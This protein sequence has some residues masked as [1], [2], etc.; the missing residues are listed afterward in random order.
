MSL[1]V[2]GSF[3]ISHNYAP[4]H[5]A[6]ELDISVEEYLKMENGEQLVTTEQAGKL[7]SF[8]KVDPALFFLK[9]LSVTNYNHGPNSHSGP[10]TTYNNNYGFKE[11]IEKLMIENDELKKEIQKLK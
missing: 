10:I 3:R 11:L 1:T 2:I 6:A 4:E 8:Y 9:G 7:A 5:L